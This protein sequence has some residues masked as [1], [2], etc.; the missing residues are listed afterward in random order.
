MKMVR[1]SFTGALGIGSRLL[2]PSEE[3]A[4]VIWRYD[5]PGDAWETR[6]VIAD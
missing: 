5:Q 4:S 1:R 6:L 2:S 3:W